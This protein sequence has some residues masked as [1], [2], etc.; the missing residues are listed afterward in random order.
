MR[1]MLFRGKTVNTKEWVEGGIIPLDIESGY[2]FIAEPYLS[3]ST[4]PIYEIIKHH[5]HL[6]IPE[7][8]G[9]FVGLIDRN[10]QKIFEGD[11]VTFCGITGLVNFNM[12]C[13]CIRTDKPDWKARN[14]PAIDIVFNEYENEVRVVGNMYDSPEFVKEIVK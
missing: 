11:V 9:Q 2:V 4:L 3:A 12:G 7:S 6:V 14:N 1:E 10:G 5:T 8:V 13:F